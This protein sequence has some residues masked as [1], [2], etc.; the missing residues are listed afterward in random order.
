MS[1][2]EQLAPITLVEH[3]SPGLPGQRHQ[4]SYRVCVVTGSSVH[5]LQQETGEG[6]LGRLR[7]LQRAREYCTERGMSVI[8][9]MLDS[10]RSNPK[11]SHS[12]YWTRLVARLRA[13]GVI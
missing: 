6:P 4:W 12:M 7:A 9:M 5:V 10:S 3:F 2:A 13:Q 1:A 11:I 8:E